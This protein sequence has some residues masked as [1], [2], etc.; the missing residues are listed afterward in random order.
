[1]S[2]PRPTS[3]AIRTLLFFALCAALIG[4]L[5]AAPAQA[6]ID[7]PLP[8]D[9]TTAEFGDVG[10]SFLLSS[11]VEQTGEPTNPNQ[12]GGVQLAPIGTLDW[13]GTADNIPQP[14]NEIR[15]VAIGKYIFAIG[16]FASNTFFDTVYRG[17]VDQ[18]T[19]SITWTTE[20]QSLPAVQHST[21]NGAAG[22]FTGASSG[23]SN[24]AVAALVTDAAAGNGLIYVIGGSVRTSTN[25]QTISSRSVLA[26]VVQG[27]DLVEW[28]KV[29]DGESDVSQ[30]GVDGLLPQSYPDALNAFHN[31]RRGVDGAS[32]FIATVGGS[33]YLY[34]VGGRTIGPNNTG[35]SFISNGIT[36]RIVYAR[37]DS[38]STGDLTWVS[39][40]SA[41]TYFDI[42]N[43]FG[44]QGFANGALVAGQFAGAD[45]QTQ[46]AFFYTGGQT[47]AGATPSYTSR[48]I[49]G[50]IGS[51]GAVTFEGSAGSGD[52]ALLD[53]RNNHG[54]VLWDNAIYTLA[55]KESTSAPT[56]NPESMVSAVN[57]QRV[58]STQPSGGNFQRLS[59]PGGTAPPQRYAGGYV[60]V[61]SATPRVSYVYYIGG[62]NGS[63]ESAEVN[64]AT[65]GEPPTTPNYPADGWYFSAPFPIAL[66]GSAVR[67]KTVKWQGKDVTASG[68]DLLVSY[69]TSAKADCS[70]LLTDPASEQPS[71]TDTL[72]AVVASGEGAGVAPYS[73][74]GANEVTLASEP[75]NCFQYRVKLQR[76]ADPTRTPSL[77]RLSIVV[78]RP[79]SA[80]L[81]FVGSGIEPRTENNK[82]TDLWIS[83]T[84]KNDFE[85]PTLPAD[86]GEQGSFTLDL[87]IFPA[88]V[89]PDVPPTDYANDF[90]LTPYNRA[91]M[92]IN[93]SLLKADP[94]Q[95]YV[96]GLGDARWW[97]SKAD[98]TLVKGGI[99]PAE[100]FPNVGT[101]TV[102]AVV[103][104]PTCRTDGTDDG[105]RGCVVE[106]AVGYDGYDYNTNNPAEDNNVSGQ[107]S[108][109]ISQVP[110][111][112]V[113]TDP[114][115]SDTS[116]YL[117]VI[118]R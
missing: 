77:I 75:A 59:D 27:G 114:N 68:G 73:R 30:P 69:R 63:A 100:L 74:D 33:T 4:A 116:I 67:V 40:G 66:G 26:G 97:W 109:T 58:L 47:S 101:Y 23:R 107:V 57:E 54:A 90:P 117:P 45:G 87:F 17:E 46:T 6:A 118:G 113:P 108:L 15:A 99:N 106:T 61:P 19:G 70:T 98:G 92:Q 11:L 31:Q 43:T 82:L 39:N 20:A 71:W 50:A 38:T 80:D 72:D 25:A 8:V 104:G 52:G 35:T 64:R 51:D 41:G 91:T 53:A 83:I 84:N 88:G 103:D 36:R 86:Y 13:K 65:I 22:N 110:D 79:G 16:G 34:V 28:R 49:K 76:G 21:A 81:K 9:D 3:R 78:L 111:P 10:A 29:G 1:M 93:R 32:A 24:I 112:T 89:S 102:V 85:T 48:V 42:P 37:I 14:R 12:Q 2:A 56:V 44:E 96:V 55:G 7:Y 94:P 62:T 60:V 115:P 5:P 18:A 105:I 95:P